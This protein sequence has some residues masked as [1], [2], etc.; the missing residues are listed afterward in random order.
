M[1]QAAKADGVVA[2]PASDVSMGALAAFATR[3]SGDLGEGFEPP[4]TR[5]AWRAVLRDPSQ[6]WY[7]IVAGANK[8]HATTVI[9]L[10]VFSRW[11]TAPW[12]SAEIGFGLDATVV[13]QGV[14]QRTVPRILLA[15]LSDDLARIEARV[16]PSNGRAS[17]ALSALGFRFEGHA[18]GCLDGVDG[19]RTQ[20]QWAII[21]ADLA[22][23]G[24][25]ANH[26]ESITD[27]TDRAAGHG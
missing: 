25:P 11:T 20:E 16:D 26:T 13:G 21:T 10:V 3:N 4:P 8:G 14:I 17:R 22:D 23:D 1:K 9:G 24:D 2:T 5:E 6:R 19:R 15:L 7:A 12:R 18:R 27:E